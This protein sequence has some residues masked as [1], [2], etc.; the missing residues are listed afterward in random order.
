MGWRVLYIEESDSVSLYLD[1]VKVKR[2]SNEFLFP[3]SDIT[4][5]IIID[6]FKV[7]ISLHLINA[8]AE[9]NIPI[10]SCGDNHH[11][12]SILFHYLDISRA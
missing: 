11:P 8:C 5:I 9:Y 10:I 7:L 6:N 1:N 2:G 12:L 3:L 4:F